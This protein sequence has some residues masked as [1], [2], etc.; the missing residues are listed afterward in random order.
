MNGQRYAL[1]SRDIVARVIDGEA[2]IINLASGLYYNTRGVGAVVWEGIEAGSPLIEIINSVCRQFTVSSEVAEVDVS[3]LIAE[4]L[5]EQLIRGD[6]VLASE[7]SS[8]LP[9]TTAVLPYEAPS[10]VKF[11][12]MAQFLALDPPLPSLEP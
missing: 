10:L 8:V 9:P 5:A 12:D 6:G 4:L 3:S 11:S 1:A 7:V 2:I